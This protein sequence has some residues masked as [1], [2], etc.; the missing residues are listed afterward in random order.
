M[1][2][3]SLI[4]QGSSILHMI[5]LT[6][7]TGS[8]ESASFPVMTLDVSPAGER[9]GQ[10]GGR[11]WGQ[12]APS[13]WRAAVPGSAFHLHGPSGLAHPQSPQPGLQEEWVPFLPLFLFS[14]LFLFS[15]GFLSICLLLLP[16]FFYFLYSFSL[17]FFFTSLSDP[18]PSFHLLSSPSFLVTS[19]A[20][21]I[22]ESLKAHFLHIM[23]SPLS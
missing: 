22:W 14:V 13:P 9:D 18:F 4:V 1:S 21:D 23:R 19:F 20:L 8:F 15:F 10:C 3:I 16:S 11:L 6:I 7:L 17:F 5:V 2:L 12:L